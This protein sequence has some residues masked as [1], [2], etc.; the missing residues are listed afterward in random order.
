MGELWITAHGITAEVFKSL[1]LCVLIRIGTIDSAHA[2]QLD[3]V[4]RSYDG[5]L[6]STPNLSC[7]SW[8][9]AVMERLVEQSPV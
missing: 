5:Q 6:N 9:F 4:M 1:F 2:S 7:D 3:S 8:L